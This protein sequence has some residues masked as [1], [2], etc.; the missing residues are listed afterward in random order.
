MKGNTLAQ[1]M[2]DLITMGGPEKEFVRGDKFYFLESTFNHD[3]NLIELHIDEYDNRDP[4]KDVH[5]KRH[6]FFG[7]NNTECVRQFEIAS[8]FDGATIY[9]AE[10]E[11]TVLFG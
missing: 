6:S 1:F 4:N 3:K 7:E 5:L 2:D 10:Q 11:I 8:I 9:G